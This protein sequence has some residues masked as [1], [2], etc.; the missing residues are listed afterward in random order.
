MFIVKFPTRRDFIERTAALTGSLGFAASCGSLLAAD[1]KQVDP[2]AFNRLRSKLKGRLVLPGDSAY[3]N[4]RRVFYWNPRTQR[5]P[6]A[7]VQCGHEEDAARA[8]EFARRHELEIAVR[9]GGHSHLAWGSSN[10]LVIDLYPLKQITIDADRRIVRAQAGVLSGEVARAASRHGLAPVLGQC[11]GVGA[12]GL[13][14][15]GGLGWLSGLFGA[16]CD[17]LLSARLITA[18]A[19]TLDVNGQTD[20]NLFWALR[21]AG[22][23]FGVT[24]S[25]EAR[26]H[27]V[28]Q[29]VAGDIHYAVRDAPA[30]LR[31]FR[32]LMHGAPDGFQAT[33]NLTPG[34]RGIFLSLCHTGDDREAERILRTLRSFASPTKEAVQR[35]PFATLAE[36][37]AATNPGN[38]PPPA[39]RAIQTVYRDRVTDEIIDIYVD[40]L[41]HASA[42]TIMGL[43]HYMHGE[44][45]RVKPDATAFPHRQADSVHLRVAYNW[46]DPGANEK[47]LAWGDEWLRLLRPASDERIYAN[48]QTYETKAGSPSVF[49]PNH[50]R[51]LA[52]KNQYDPTNFFRRNANVAPPN[53]PAPPDGKPT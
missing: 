45:C 33:L 21:G 42:D 8:V 13:T 47:R 24:T 12:T 16:S 27:P 44:V 30:V 46:S 4:A 52:L 38:A 48:Y 39:F 1:E 34:E 49:G 17:N 43:S 36:K 18:D 37:A 29:V 15:G 40:Q 41:A 51:L 2:D 23:N 10:G 11:P 3:E 32:D 9:A 25:F 22:A 35:Q 53:S 5:A 50:R 28:G 20:P 26:L 7:V 6:A 19:R 31:G 14:L